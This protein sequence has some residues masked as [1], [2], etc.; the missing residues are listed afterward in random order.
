LPV[1]AI[2]ETIKKI[3]MSQRTC[4]SQN[5]IFE[6][7]SDFHR[8]SVYNDIIKVNTFLGYRLIADTTP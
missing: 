5:D 3:A 4:P 7:L 1:V 2:S 6:Y 8:T